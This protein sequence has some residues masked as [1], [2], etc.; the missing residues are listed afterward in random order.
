MEQ[1]K[2]AEARLE[3]QRVRLDA[4]GQDVAFFD[5]EIDRCRQERNQLILERADYAT[6]ELQIRFLL[7]LL[8][9]MALDDDEREAPEL[10]GACPDYEDFFRW[11]RHP[12][13]DGLILNGE[14]TRFDNDLVI[15][16]L[17]K[18]DVLDDGKFDVRFKAGVSIRV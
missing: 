15:R 10:H 14:I 3:E 17:D 6:Q 12:V 1:S 16:Y 18:V 7:E 8:D 4:E 11:T 9:D 2:E 13:P 5:A